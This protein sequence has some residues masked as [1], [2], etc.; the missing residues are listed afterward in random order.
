VK[1]KFFD[2]QET[3]VTR[4][5]LLALV[6]L[7][8]AI[9]QQGH[10]LTGTWN[11]DWGVNS[12]PRTQITVVMSWDGKA[13]SGKINP[14]PDAAPLANVVVD[15]T[16]WTVRFEADLKDSSGK[17]S[18][19]M[20]EGHIDDLGSYHRTLTGSWR[21]GANKGDFKLTRD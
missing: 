15:P 1:C 10:P 20:A 4:R 14:G 18:H 12:G 11:G 5:A 21:Q 7:I 16:T 8:Q 17:P 2:A 9:A 19:V 3:L 13:V 6:I